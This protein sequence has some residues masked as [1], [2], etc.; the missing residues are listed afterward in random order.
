M[1]AAL[2][3]RLRSAEGRFLPISE[4]GGA[5]ATADLD[6]LERFG[7]L[8]ERHPLLG[9]AYRGPSP[10][11]CPDQ[12]EWRLDTRRIGRRVAVWSRVASTNDLAAAASGSSA[13]E[14]LVVL[15]EE[16]TSGRGRRGRSW[17]AP[18]GSSLLMSALL[19]PRG[20]IDDP[21][22]LTAL[23]AVATAEVVEQAAGREARIKWPND[24]RV[25]GRKIA[26]VLVERGKGTVVGI[27][28]NVSMT[29]EDFPEPLRG[30]ATSLR[31]LTG[32]PSDRSDLARA[33]IRRLDVL[34]DEG[35][36]LGTGPLALAWRGRLEP[37]GRDLTLST[38]SGDVEGRLVEADLIRGLRVAPRGGGDRWFGHVEVL[39]L[40]GERFADPD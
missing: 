39:G 29:S 33:L 7:F 17:V 8:L 5:A 24:V 9:V 34:Y 37:L 27:G 21:S 28:V 15:A 20:P 10:W 30:T 13:N 6:D 3:D 11:L 23:G 25:D 1:N 4:L 32:G 16:Q 12:I 19:F 35:M 26:G 36:R 22:W 38:A 31:M 18:P 14:G 2:L 40:D